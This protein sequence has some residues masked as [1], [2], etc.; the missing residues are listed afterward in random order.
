MVAQALYELN[1]ARM[2]PLANLDPEV[3][4]P[5]QLLTSNKTEIILTLSWCQLSKLATRGIITPTE[6]FQELHHSAKSRCL[7]P[8]LLQY[9]T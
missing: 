5:T 2:E 3:H 4:I 6:T 8:G 9:T 7:D 1:M